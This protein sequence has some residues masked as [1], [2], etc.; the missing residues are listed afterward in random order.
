[1]AD[2][3][4]LP[5]PTPSACPECGTMRVVAEGLNSVRIARADTNLLGQALGSNN[6]ELWALVCPQ[7]GHTTFYA[8]NPGHLA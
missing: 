4:T 5:Q 6:S 1:M 8:K 7:C 2:D 3:Q